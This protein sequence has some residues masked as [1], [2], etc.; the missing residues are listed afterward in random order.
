MIKDVMIAGGLWL[1][2]W[3]ESCW[4]QNQVKIIENNG[5]R[6]DELSELLPKAMIIYGDASATDLS[7]RRD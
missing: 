5:A 6:C 4:N 1:I 7:G 3:Q 2:I